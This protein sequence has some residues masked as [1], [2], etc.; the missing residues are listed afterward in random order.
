MSRQALQLGQTGEDIAS[1]FLIKNGYKILKRNYKN[2][3]GEIDIIALEGDEICFVEVKTRKSTEFGLPEEAVSEKK[4]KKL[5]LIAL[6]YLKE[7]DLLD[8]F[9]RFDVVSVVFTSNAAQPELIK[10]AFEVVQ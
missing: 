9:A 2:R 7:N 4:Q 1:N 6:A 5:T 10:N 8:R 3:L